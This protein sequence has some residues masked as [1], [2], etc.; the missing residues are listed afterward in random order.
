MIFG[1]FFGLVFNLGNRI[2]DYG[3]ECLIFCY[4]SD[5][6]MFQGSQHY[7]EENLK[8]Y[9][10][11]ITKEGEGLSLKKVI[12]QTGVASEQKSKLNN[13]FAKIF[14]RGKM[15]DYPSFQSIDKKPEDN[16]LPE[17]LSIRQMDKPNEALDD[18][19]ARLNSEP[20]VPKEVNL[21]EYIKYKI[22]KD[23]QSEKSVLKNQEAK[24]HLSQSEKVILE[25]KT[26]GSNKLDRKI[27]KYKGN[28]IIEIDKDEDE[29]SE[30]DSDDSIGPVPKYDN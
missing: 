18:S 24:S 20:E 28:E 13:F 5:E 30:N 11:Q 26:K 27:Y 1:V 17:N 21:Q 14:R 8:G 22:N 12:A 4:V 16:N 7:Y 10:N 15:E 19:K 29:D 9:L 3:A 6:E 23:S 25:E 2:V